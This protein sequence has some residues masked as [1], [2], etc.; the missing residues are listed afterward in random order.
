[1]VVTLVIRLLPCTST[2]NFA[3]WVETGSER[4]AAEET[5][6]ARKLSDLTRHFLDGTFEVF[7]RAEFYGVA[8]FDFDGFTGLGVTAFARLSTNF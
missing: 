2:Q 1:M 6:P 4:I 8:G 3:G 7:A 5:Q